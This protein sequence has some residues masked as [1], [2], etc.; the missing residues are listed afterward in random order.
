MKILVVGMSPLPI[1]LEEALASKCVVTT[2]T[3]RQNLLFQ[4]ATQQFDCVLIWS[5][6]ISY[7]I[8]KKIVKHLLGR[9]PSLKILVCGCAYSSPERAMILMEGV[10]DCV[11]SSIGAAELIAKVT[12]IAQSDQAVDH[13]A[14]FTAGDFSF[15]FIQNLASYRGVVIPLN[16]KE[17][18]MLNT[19]LRHRNNILSKQMLYDLI[20]DSASTPTSNS[21]EVYVSSLRRKIEKP[22]GLKL[23]ETVKGVGYR[24]RNE[25]T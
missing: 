2:C 21:L 19:L 9:F 18:L 3:L 6:K 12:I 4:I 24:V 17:S 20:W 23:I 16:R 7:L 5:E 8:L 14:V 25:L 1:E 15:N 22:F 11:A 10:K 13:K